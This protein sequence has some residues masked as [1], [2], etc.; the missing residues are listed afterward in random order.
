MAPPAHEQRTSALRVISS[1]PVLSR[2][3]REAL[4]P[5][6][7]R[8]EPV[9]VAARR[10]LFEPG[11][12]T[13]AFLVSGGACALHATADRRSAVLGIAGPGELVGEE[14]IALGRHR[15]AAL[16]LGD[17]DA[18]RIPLAVLSRLCAE[19]PRVA[20]ALAELVERRRAW[21]ERRLTS[22][23]EDEVADRVRGLLGELAAR[24]GEPH[25][26]GVRI[27]LRITH[28]DIAAA[29]GATRETVTGA[30]A[31]LRAAG[32]LL[33]EGRRLIV[34]RREMAAASAD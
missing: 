2:A 3:G 12:A 20:M 27:V 4:G 17:V 28:A 10:W 31:A 11:R 34:P 7:S 26:R 22:L 23:V 29:V 16:A 21:L 13:A 19:N 5:L 1:C 8:C 15:R 30:L 18:L 25:P 32:K 33:T 14:A 9:R 6:A 24:F